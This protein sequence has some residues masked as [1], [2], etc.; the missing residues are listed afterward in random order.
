MLS[1]ETPIV[2]IHLGAAPPPYMRIAVTQARR[3]NPA[4]PIFC[5]SSVVESYGVGETW[6]DAGDIPM[7]AA[8]KRFRD[9]T[10]LRGFWQWT[11][12]R[13]F[14][15]EEWMR[16]KDIEECFHFENDNLIYE[17][18]SL[19]TPLLRETSRG[20]STTF[21]GQGAAR[22]S[23]RICLSA[24]YCK[25]VDA[26][27]NLAMYL[28]GTASNVNEM[29]RCGL[30]WQD[31][32][33]ECSFLPTV[34][35][36]STLESEAFRSWIEDA[37]FSSIGC[38]FDSS[39]HGQYLGGTDANY[40]PIG[41]GYINPDSDYRADQFVYIWITDEVGRRYPSIADKDGRQWKIANLHIH[42]KRLQEFI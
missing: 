15:L 16:W 21:Q 24:L 7:S 14:I 9:I 11:T 41:P 26:L 35:L 5:L 4:A 13:L 8:H 36:G 40:S 34:P 23:L 39:T 17:D 19:I 18:I 32:P 22:N 1:G 28:A 42:C 38:V 30:Y 20:L 6:V 31:T 3:W 12:E 37:R 27:G 33:E 10:P 29:E 25:S 2:F